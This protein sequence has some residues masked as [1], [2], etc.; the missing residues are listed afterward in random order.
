M[1]MYSPGTY[2]SVEIYEY[3][4]DAWQEKTSILYAG[5]IDKVL[6]NGENIILQEGTKLMKYYQQINA[7][8]ITLSD[9]RYPVTSCEIGLDTNT[10]SLTI[11]S[12]ADFSGNISASSADFSTATILDYLS[13]PFKIGSNDVFSVG[14]TVNTSLRADAAIP[15]G[16]DVYI[17]CS[18][19]NRNYP[20][21]E[22]GYT[23]RDHIALQISRPRAGGVGESIDGSGQGTIIRINHDDRGTVDLFTRSESTDK[24]NTMGFGIRLGNQNDSTS[25]TPLYVNNKNQVKIGYDSPQTDDTYTLD[26]NGSVSASSYT[27]STNGIID[28]G[29]GIYINGKNSG[30]S[31]E[32]YAGVVSDNQDTTEEFRFH[33]EGSNSTIN[34]RI[35]GTFYADNTSIT[36]DD[37][38]KINEKF[39]ENAINTLKKL[40]PQIYEKHIKLNSTRTFIESG[41]IAQEIYYDAPELR[42]LVS[43]PKDATIEDTEPI[44]SS[45]DPQQD[46]DYSKWGSEPASVNYTGFIAYLIKAIQEQ[47]IEIEAYKEKTNSLETTLEELVLR[48]EKLENV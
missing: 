8:V 2:D 31:W 45:D 4:E 10:N 27:L 26:V 37:R 7:S 6:S 39:I 25:S 18:G 21:D 23:Y 35:D 1:I 33:G 22:N 11:S 34:L 46:P 5:N 47:Q 32:G 17:R 14:T 42:H 41:L 28:L 30:Y 43:V 20:V 3:N 16:P 40:R 13:T 36:S 48:I 15:T 44:K 12:S 29:N 38:L 19:N 24:D 9:S